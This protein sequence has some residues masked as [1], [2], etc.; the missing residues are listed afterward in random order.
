M[1]DPA[2]NILSASLE[3]MTT[4]AFTDV[5][6]CIFMT[7]ELT[8]GE[9]KQGVALEVITTDMPSPFDKVAEV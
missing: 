1:L 4:D 9:A 7:L 8:T 3:V 5:M 6:I 2:Q